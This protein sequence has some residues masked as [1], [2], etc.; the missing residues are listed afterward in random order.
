[1][2]AAVVTSFDHPPSWGAYTD[3][4][5]DGAEVLVRT[6]CAALSNLAKGRA[7]GRHYSGKAAFPFVAGVDGAGTLADGRRVYFAF[8]RAPFGTMAELV[9]VPPEYCASIPDGL[10][11]VT[12]AAI[13]NPLMSSWAALTERAHFQAGEA[14][15]INGATGVSGRLAVRVAKHLGARTVVATGRNSVQLAELSALGADVVLSLDT[16]EAELIATFAEVLAAERIAVVLDY[17]WGVPAERLM[18]AII[19]GTNHNAAPRIRYV[20]IGNSAGAVIPLQAGT[21][22]GSGIELLGSGLGSISQARLVAIIGEAF[23]AIS[24]AGLTVETVTRP[25]TGVAEAWNEETGSRRLVL[26]NS[27]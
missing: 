1:M 2:N 3:P 4:V 25:L 11:D 14:V 9:P 27:S 6:T 23:A 20:Q 17:L 24:G 16:P 8:P 15:L 13:A 26:T 19:S 18:S 10:D 7:A 12:A 21:L 5:L 22:R